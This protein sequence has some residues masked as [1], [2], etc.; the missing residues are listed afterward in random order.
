MEVRGGNIDIPKRFGQSE[1]DLTHSR[2]EAGDPERLSATSPARNRTRPRKRVPVSSAGNASNT[3]P[4]PIVIT[5]I[6]GIHADPTW[7]GGS[8]GQSASAISE[9]GNRRDQLRALFSGDPST[10]SETGLHTKFAE[11]SEDTA[12]N[13][14]LYLKGWL[15][16]RLAYRIRS[17]WIQALMKDGWVERQCPKRTRPFRAIVKLR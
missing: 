9:K 7:Q 17:N 13:R 15:T 16:P 6:T 5:W 14:P 2:E 3:E 11:H 12:E 1:T 4:A 8:S 10:S